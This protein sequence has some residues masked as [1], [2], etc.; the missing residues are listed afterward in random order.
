VRADVSI[1]ILPTG[2]IV[3]LYPHPCPACRVGR[4]VWMNRDGV[5]ICYDCDQRA[6][7]A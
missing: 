4:C 7:A 3:S 2:V 1:L 5:T 6:V